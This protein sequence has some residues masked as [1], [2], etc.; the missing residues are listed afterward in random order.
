ME[1]AKTY[2]VLPVKEEFFDNFVPSSDNFY[3]TPFNYQQQH[4]YPLRSGTHQTS[5]VKEIGCDNYD[6]ISDQYIRPPPHGSASNPL[7]L[8]CY[9]CE[10]NAGHYDKGLLDWFCNPV[11][12]FEFNGPTMDNG[13]NACALPSRSQSVSTNIAAGFVESAYEENSHPV[14]DHRLDRKRKWPEMVPD[15]YHIANEPAYTNLSI[16]D[17]SLNRRQIRRAGPNGGVHPILSRNFESHGYT[18]TGAIPACNGFCGTEISISYSRSIQACVG[19]SPGSCRFC[20][21][22]PTNDGL[23]RY[24]GFQDQNYSARTR[25]TTNSKHLFHYAWTNMKS[26]V[27]IIIQIG[28]Y[29]TFS[30]ARVHAHSLSKWISFF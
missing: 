23:L 27:V 5:E 21:M 20:C 19:Y 8:S 6:H 22:P 9:T 29:C 16:G 18:E 28:V 26:L 14:D 12:N 30:I 15:S 1:P 13:I 24:P 2:Q 4:K 11:S 25:S 10:T 3:G 7:H 17:T